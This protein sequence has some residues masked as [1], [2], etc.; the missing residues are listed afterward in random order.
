MGPG[1]VTAS[2]ARLLIFR[3]RVTRLGCIYGPRQASRRRGC[4]K[5]SELRGSRHTKRGG[6]SNRL[7][8]GDRPRRH[9][10]YPVCQPVDVSKL[11]KLNTRNTMP[12]AR[13]CG[14]GA[15]RSTNRIGA[16]NSHPQ[17]FCDLRHATVQHPYPSSHRSRQHDT[18]QVRARIMDLPFLSH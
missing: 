13:L 5:Q 9:Y 6:D 10:N 16:N 11:S 3:S 4:C 12:S 8:L 7:A 14:S 18:V 1:C 2:K 17:K 15:H